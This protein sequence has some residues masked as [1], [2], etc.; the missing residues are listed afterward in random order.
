MLYLDVGNRSIKA[1]RFTGGGWTRVGRYDHADLESVRE[2]ARRE[3]VV[4]CSV[5]VAVAS[6]LPEVEWFDRTAIPADRLDYETPETLGVDR[7]LACE[8]ARVLSGKDVVVVDAG[9]AVTIDWM[10]ASGVFHGGV[11]MPGLGLM[12]DA[13][14]RHAPALPEVERG[15]PATFPP[16]STRDALKAG[17][18]MSWSGIVAA[19]VRAMKVL[20]P[21]SDVW[22]TG[23]DAAHLSLPGSR[24]DSDLVFRGL[25]VFRP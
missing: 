14:K 22:L 8:G 6:A 15:H 20:C 1:A 21:D 12:E 18:Y 17:L 5:V 25:R 2:L 16:K 3:Q 24:S 4:G 10:D 13:L 7:F 11:I 23:Q 9:T 19:H